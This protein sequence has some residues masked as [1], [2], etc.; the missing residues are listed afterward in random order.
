M[1]VG[2][3]QVYDAALE[4][5]FNSTFDLD[6]DSYRFTLHTSAYTHAGTHSTWSDVSA[7]EHAASGGY[8]A[9]GV[10]IASAT[11]TETAGVIKF[12]AAKANFGATTTITAEYIIATKMDGGSLTAA[13]ELLGYMHLDT[14]GTGATS[15]NG[16]FE[17]RWNSVDGTGTLFTAQQ[18]T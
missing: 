17:V 9:D 15:S 7:S 16:K 8:S 11:V 14:T 13:D 12:K 2:N 10:A 5:I 3:F 18:T 4:K 1:A 6:A